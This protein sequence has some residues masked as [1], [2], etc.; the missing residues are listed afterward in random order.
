MFAQP[1]VRQS[2]TGYSLDDAARIH[3]ALLHGG[4]PLRCPRC[5]KSLS[6]TVG[7]DDAQAVWLLRCQTCERSVLIRDTQPAW[8]DTVTVSVPE[9]GNA[10]APGTA[11]TNAV[12]GR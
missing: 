2:G 6:G 5:G 3:N 11:E 1:R 4:S 7:V 10:I 9:R 12:D 8:S